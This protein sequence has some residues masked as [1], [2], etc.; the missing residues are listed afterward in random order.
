M[1]RSRVIDRFG[2]MVATADSAEDASL[3]ATA[4]DMYEVLDGIENDDQYR[5][6]EDE[7]RAVAGIFTAHL[8]A[9]SPFEDFEPSGTGIEAINARFR[10][11]HGRVLAD[12]RHAGVLGNVIRLDDFR[13]AEH[14]QPRIDQPVGNHAE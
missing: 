2:R 13:A 4:P 10:E 11:G 12:H 7:F 3:I 9:G 5:M 1:N 8:H 6:V 14:F